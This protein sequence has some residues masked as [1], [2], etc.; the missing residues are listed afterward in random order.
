MMKRVKIAALVLAAGTLTSAD[1]KTASPSID[2]VIAAAIAAPATVSYSGVVEVVRMGSRIA[3]ASVY[4][5]EHRAPG[6]TR[7]VYVAPSMLT[8][9]WVV[10]DGDAIY[11]IDPKL[12]RMVESR[13]DGAD[14]SSA[15]HANYALLRQN[16][17]AVR[18]GNDIIA[19]RR[20]IDVALVNNAT[21]RTIML[22]RVDAVTKCVL[23]K[24]SFSA[25]GAPIDEVRF[26]TIS[27]SSAL[28][29]T[30]FALPKGYAVVRAPS[31]TPSE[32]PNRVVGDAGFAARAP[33]VL[34]GGFAPV[35]GNIVDLHGVR[36][37]HLLYS[38]GLRTISLFESAQSATF[39]SARFESHSVVIAGHSAQYGEDGTTALL[40]WSDGRLYYTLVGEVGLIDLKGLA[41][42]MER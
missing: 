37:M 9:E 21:E 13:N 42:E 19:G 3:E 36:T 31:F 11:S 26:E 30:D 6:L 1:A 25:S 40:S 2:P 4:R 41:D 22:I 17:H 16:Y 29:R 32:P 18:A 33:R 24:K 34:P 23:E 14:D 28:P 38:D 8:G 27:Y 15:L 39:A 12:R 7:R 10:A 5:I 35:D 20:T